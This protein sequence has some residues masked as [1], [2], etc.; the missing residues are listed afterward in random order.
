MQYHLQSKKMVLIL[1]AQACFHSTL[2]GVTCSCIQTIKLRRNLYR[3]THTFLQAT[4]LPMYR[5]IKIKP[6]PI[7]SEHAASVDLNIACKRSSFTR[8]AQLTSMSLMD[9]LI[10]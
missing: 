3:W 4:R 8:Q 1:V 9:R 7:E 2:L 6:P 5:G 10:I